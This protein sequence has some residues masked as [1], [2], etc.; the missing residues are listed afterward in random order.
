MDFDRERKLPFTHLVL[1]ILHLGK[2]SIQRELDKLFQALGQM[3][4]IT[5]GALTHARKKLC[6][7]VF[8]AL[9]DT[10]VQN[11]YTYDSALV[12]NGIQRILAV[13][14]SRI[15]LPETEK[16]VL[17]FGRA[18]KQPDAKTTSFSIGI[19]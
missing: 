12:K 16:M 1:A 8:I 3:Q 4:K 14:G 17:E 6:P 10:L 18:N 2:A 11:F 13:D 7:E 15:E 9:N 19:V 5:A